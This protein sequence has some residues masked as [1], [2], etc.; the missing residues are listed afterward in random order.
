M[1][2][3]ILGQE[4]PVYFSP[5]L[6]AIL[7]ARAKEVV[8]V[9]IVGSRGAG[10]HPKTF[11]EKLKNLYSLWRLLEP[12]GF[13]DHLRVRCYQ[14]LLTMFGLLGTYL[15]KRSL[16]GAA[17]SHDIEIQRITDVNDPSFLAKLRSLAPDLIINQTELLLKKELLSIPKIGILNRHASLLPHFRGRLGS[18]WGHAQD[19]PEYGVTIH[20]VNEE[21]DAG[22]IVV[23]KRFELDPTLSFSKILGILFEESAAL[24]LEAIDKVGGKG[25]S[26]LPNNYKE[27][28]PFKFPTLEQIQNYRKVLKRRRAKFDVP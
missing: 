17:K 19:F 12:M 22:P 20:F 28:T 13:L 7:N 14:A 27:T 10:S 24:M 1:R 5:F 2:I 16:E 25:F 4:E 15:D 18:F 21:I 11:G 3:V 26:S 8:S 23:Q 9:A 6:R